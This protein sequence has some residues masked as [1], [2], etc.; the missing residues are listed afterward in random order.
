MQSKSFL[1]FPQRKKEQNQ[2]VSPKQT[3]TEKT[4]SQRKSKKTRVRKQKQKAGNS[5]KKDKIQSSPFPSFH[6][7]LN[8]LLL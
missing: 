1:P 3:S 8:R 6:S 5:Q 7:H 2:I 4:S